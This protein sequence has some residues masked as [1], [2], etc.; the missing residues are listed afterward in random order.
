LTFH[1]G[2]R[3]NERWSEAGFVNRSTAIPLKTPGR[4]T[5][6]STMAV[7]FG[8]HP[9]HELPGLGVTAARAKE[10]HERLVAAR[11]ALNS[12]DAGQGTLREK[13]DA[14]FAQLRRRLSS[15]VGELRLLLE[16]ESRLWEA[17]GLNI[18]GRRGRKGKLEEEGA[19]LQVVA[20][21]DA[22]EAKAA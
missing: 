16:L 7:Y 19:G 17:F 12:Q 10:L 5:L 11:K 9:E 4:E 13:R 20:K 15:A 21:S 2:A 6:I 1:L 8:K 3:W 18:P 14:S 22:P